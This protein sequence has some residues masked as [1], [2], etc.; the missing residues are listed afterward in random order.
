MLTDRRPGDMEAFRQQFNVNG[1]DTRR[2]FT[3]TNVPVKNPR[4]TTNEMRDWFTF[5]YE[6][7]NA[8]HSEEKK[9]YQGVYMSSETPQA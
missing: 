2:K 6:I 1:G 8:L 5:E 9:C 4:Y 7:G 3:M